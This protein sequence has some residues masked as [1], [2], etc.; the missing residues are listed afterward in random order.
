MSSSVH[1]ILFRDYVDAAARH[2]QNQRFRSWKCYHFDRLHMCRSSPQSS[3]VTARTSEPRGLS[4]PPQL[5]RTRLELGAGATRGR[6]P[7]Y[8]GPARRYARPRPPLPRPVPP[9]RSN[10]LGPRTRIRPQEARSTDCP[11]L[12]L[13]RHA[14]LLANRRKMPGIVSKDLVW[15][16]RRG[17]AGGLCPPERPRRALAGFPGPRRLPGPFGSDRA[18]ARVQ[19]AHSRDGP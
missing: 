17:S 5:R 14:K 7:L 12:A 16:A 11:K 19:E 2:P 4:W 8:C 1:V 10:W 15:A 18:P 13:D 9:P 3:K 6:F